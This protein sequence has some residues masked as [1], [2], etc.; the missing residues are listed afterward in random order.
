[1]RVGAVKREVC[2][3]FAFMASTSCVPVD[4]AV[5]SLSKAIVTLRDVLKSYGVSRA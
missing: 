4:I 5:L 1:M 3:K 2:A